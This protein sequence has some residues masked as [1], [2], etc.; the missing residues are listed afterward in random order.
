MSHS[1]KQ[2]WVLVFDLCQRNIG[3]G[4]NADLVITK[5]FQ[6]REDM[7]P[8]DICMECWAKI[9]TLVHEEDGD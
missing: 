8:L 9:K 1:R 3:I 7:L 5:P 4:K 6:P 2:V